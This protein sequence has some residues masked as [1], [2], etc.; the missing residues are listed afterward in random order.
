MLAQLDAI[1]V[2]LESRGPDGVAAD[3]CVDSL[4]S[5]LTAALAWHDSAVQAGGKLWSEA[6]FDDLLYRARKALESARESQS[7]QDLAATWR[8]LKDATKDTYFV[9]DY[10]QTMTHAGRSRPGK[11]PVNGTNRRER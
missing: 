3:G 10:L 4:A 7:R 2:D 6:R 8:C 5:L 11:L 1:A 9:V